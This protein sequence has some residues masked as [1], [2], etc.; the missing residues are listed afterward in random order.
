MLW[1]EG[2]RISRFWFG[3]YNFRS[4]CSL[5]FYLHGHR[6]YAKVGF[7]GYVPGG[8]SFLVV[9]IYYYALFSSLFLFI[10]GVV[11]AVRGDIWVGRICDVLLVLLL[12]CYVFSLFYPFLVG[13]VLLV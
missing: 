5:L 4:L 3:V 13:S 2:E 12:L 11:F 10:L 7:F 6:T 8:E 1:G 9:P